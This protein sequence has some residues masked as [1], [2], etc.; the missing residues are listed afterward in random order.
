V[1]CD[2]RKYTAAMKDLMVILI[3]DPEMVHSRVLLGKTLKMSGELGKAEEQMVHVIRMES[4]M[5]S[6]HAELGDIRL[7]MREKSK[8]KLAVKGTRLRSAHRTTPDYLNTF[9]HV[10]L[11]R[12]LPPVIDLLCRFCESCSALG[13]AE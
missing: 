3:Q 1:Y 9:S 8:L 13:A 7:L 5:Y 10:E 4:D 11:T 12:S 2:L 6:H